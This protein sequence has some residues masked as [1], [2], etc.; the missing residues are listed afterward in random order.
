MSFF[1]GVKQEPPVVN[2]EAL[3]KK[4]GEQLIRRVWCFHRVQDS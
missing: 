1:L 3:S 4:R 2:F